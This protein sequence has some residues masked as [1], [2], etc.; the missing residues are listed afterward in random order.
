MAL[1]LS[2]DYGYLAPDVD[3]EEVQAFQADVDLAHQKVTQGMG[4]GSDFLGW[5]DPAQIVSADELQTIKTL[6]A[7]IREN[8]DVLVSI[9]IG[10]S[11]LGARAVIEA[12]GEGDGPEVLFAGNSLSAHDHARTLKE[13]GTASGSRSTLSRSRERPPSLLSRSG[14]SAICWKRTLARTKQRSALWRPPTPSA[15]H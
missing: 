14:C 11:Y 1:P 5:L 12:L 4:L 9:G 13:A 10:G 6:A 8:S 7:Q 3:K 15:G 2:F